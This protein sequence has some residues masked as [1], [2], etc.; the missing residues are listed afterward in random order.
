MKLVDGYP[1]LGLCEWRGGDVDARVF[2]R[3]QRRTVRA[4]GA[5][6]GSTIL[7]FVVQITPGWRGRNACAFFGRSTPGYLL[8]GLQPEEP[9]T[10]GTWRQD[11]NGNPQSSFVERY[12]G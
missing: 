6:S 11:W 1:Y 3:V 9:G 8:S 5:S 7:V 4:Q 12:W 10:G 2:S